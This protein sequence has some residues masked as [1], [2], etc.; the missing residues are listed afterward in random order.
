MQP[1]H[2]TRVSSIRDSLPAEIREAAFRSFTPDQIAR[3]HAYGE[4][5]SL[6]PL[7]YLYKA[8]DERY[9]FFVV[10]SGTVYIFDPTTD[11]DGLI[12]TVGENAFVGELGLLADQAPFLS[13]KVKDAARL[14]WIGR[15]GLRRIIAEEPDIADV[16]VAAFSARRELLM[17]AATANLTILGPEGSAEVTRALEYVSRNRIPHRWMDSCTGDGAAYADRLGVDREKLHVVLRGDKVVQRPDNPGIAYALGIPLDVEDGES[18]DLVVIGA[19]PGGI[20]AAVYGA[21]EGLST[22][23][24]ENTAIGG[25]AG[26]SSR[27][28]NYMGFPT[29]ISGLDLA[30][31]GQIQAIKFGAR[32][33]TPRTARSVHQ[34]EDGTF[35]IKLCNGNDICTRS[36][37][38]ATGV[39]YRR[40]P[41][42]RLEDFER[43]GVY[44][45][46]TELEAR[47]CR[48]T[49]VVVVGG[50][51]SAGQA[52]MFLASHARHVH[53]CIRRDS[54]A[55]T[56]SDYLLRRLEANP[57]VTIHAFTEVTELRGGQRLEG[58]TLTNRQTGETTA[59]ETRALFIMIGAAPN[60]DWLNDHCKL[61]EK[62]FILTGDAA[63]AESPFATSC[64]GIF[65]VGDVRSGSV[66]RVASSVGEGSVVVSAVH[67]FLAAQEMAL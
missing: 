10:L 54:L 16:I 56:M 33:A 25:Q 57:K 43:A 58:L 1:T 31:R 5:R 19:G 47:F 55:A 59:V 49:E 60:T 45:A 50:G 6:A 41:I 62:G 4:V 13:A 38:V 14:L 18:F 51:N 36:I 8:G 23:V 48:N 26:T 11:G 9:D 67:Q 61:D 46:A 32:F 35:L 22:L 2:T 52:A 42:D 17:T 40:L 63:G 66:K 15:E 20:A 39:Q 28:E 44:Y 65:A 30:Y 34:R 64:R 27:I 7:E 37:V 21:S 29:G 53:I 12:S 3:L 24:I